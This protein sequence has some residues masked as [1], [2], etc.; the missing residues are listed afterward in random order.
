MAATFCKAWQLPTVFMENEGNGFSFG[1]NFFSFLCAFFDI[2]TWM[3][4]KNCVKRLWC[5]LK[6]KTIETCLKWMVLHLSILEQQCTCVSHNV[7]RCQWCCARDGSSGGYCWPHHTPS[8]TIWPL[9]QVY[10]HCCNWQK[11]FRWS[12]MTH[13][14]T[15]WCNCYGS[16]PC[17]IPITLIKLFCIAYYTIF[18]MTM[19]RFFHIYL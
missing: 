15:A 9:A 7:W 16:L 10:V 2:I 3:L 6:A 14:Y 13:F 1:D 12:N 17:N 4:P 19:F 11:T 8:A 18:L 5:L